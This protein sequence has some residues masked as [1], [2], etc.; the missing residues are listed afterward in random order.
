V[1]DLILT[2]L[3]AHEKYG[4][5]LNFTKKEIDNLIKEHALFALIE[6]INCNERGWIVLW[7]NKYVSDEAFAKYMDLEYDIVPPFTDKKYFWIIADDFEDLLTNRYE[8]EAKVLDHEYDWYRS[9]FYDVDVEQYFYMYDQKTLEAIIEYCDKNGFE[10][11]NDNEDETILITKE[12]TKIINNEIII[13]DNIKLVDILDQLEDLD[14][15]LNNAICEAQESADQDEIYERIEKN[16]ISEVGEYTR[17]IFKINGKEQ[18]KLLVRF[19]G[20]WS[21][22][23]QALIDTY[24]EYEFQEETYGS[25]RGILNENDYFK[26]R[27]PDYNYTYG[28]I[29]KS[30]LNEYTQNRLNWD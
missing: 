2:M 9:D 30:T 27:T 25:L 11:E 20:N 23:E 26:F 19:D 1:I 21:D 18:E 17:K 24:G 22:I 12:N 5:E 29:D 15:T 14:R 7:K 6:N 13:N 4:D 10:I 3:D 28:D 16:F 8:F